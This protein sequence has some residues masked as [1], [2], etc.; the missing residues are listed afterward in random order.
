M[1]EPLLALITLPPCEDSWSS[2]LPSFTGV[3]LLVSY[4][5]VVKCGSLSYPRTK[6]DLKVSFNLMGDSF[7]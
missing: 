5:V 4:D 7:R 2:T 6:F 1:A 3:T